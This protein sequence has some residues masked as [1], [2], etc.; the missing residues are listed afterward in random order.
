MANQI[1][2]FFASQPGE[3]AA[4]GVFDHLKS[5]W[6]PN[7]RREIVAHM[8]NGGEGLTPLSRQAV[9]RLRQKS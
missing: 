9:D 4:A 2:Q 3:Q 6:T 8:N 1:S 5:L 7:M